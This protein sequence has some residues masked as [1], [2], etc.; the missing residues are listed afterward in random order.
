MQQ[1]SQAL[2][3][4]EASAHIDDDDSI[5]RFVQAHRKRMVLTMT[6]EG[7]PQD[8][9]DRVVLAHVLSDLAKTSM[10]RKRLG[11]AEKQSNM[12]REAQILIA[13]MN[14]QLKG[15]SPFEQTVIEGEATPVPREIPKLRLDPKQIEAASEFAMERG[16]GAERYDEFQQRM[17]PIMEEKRKQEARDAGLQVE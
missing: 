11:A 7:V 1:L 14:E 6:A 13:S 9:K 5:L 12:D 4:V 2:S 15:R 3:D 17:D 10:D 16:L 8:A